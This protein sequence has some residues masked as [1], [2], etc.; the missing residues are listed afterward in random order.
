[1][2]HIL[3]EGSCTV[4][5]C[6]V[7]YGSCVCVLFHHYEYV[8]GE[9]CTAATDNCTNGKRIVLLK[10]KSI[11]FYIH[12]SYM[13]RCVPYWCIYR[14]IELNVMVAGGTVTVN[15]PTI[16]KIMLKSWAVLNNVCDT[17]LTLT[18]DEMLITDKAGMARVARVA[19]QQMFSVTLCVYNV[20]FILD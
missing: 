8:V 7:R 14:F 12:L 19:R 5:Y 15:L 2:W 6:N 17:L 9:L 20:S 10:M 11:H 1:M 3:Y 4:Q 18:C 16:N 13:S